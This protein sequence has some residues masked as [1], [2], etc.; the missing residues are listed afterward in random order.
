MITVI[1]AD[2]SDNDHDDNDNNN[3]NGSNNSNI[4]EEVINSNEILKPGSENK[5]KQLKYRCW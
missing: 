4:N 2:D 3:G 1:A 5:R